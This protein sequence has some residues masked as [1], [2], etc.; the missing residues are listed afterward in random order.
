[1][2][3]FIYQ[4]LII[5]VLVIFNIYIEYTSGNNLSLPSYGSPVNS[6]F[7]VIFFLSFHFL[8][9]YLLILF[10]SKKEKNILLYS[11]WKYVPMVSFLIIVVSFFIM[12]L[13]FPSLFNFV[14]QYRVVL[15]ILIQYFLFLF[16]I[17]VFAII[18]KLLSTKEDFLKFSKRANTYSVWIVIGV[19]FLLFVV[20]G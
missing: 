9:Y 18:L 11:F 17:F 15:Y 6:V 19:F 4:L 16:Y 2:V 20:L 13:A 3:W 14:E 12:M 1:M 8:G 5:S 10:E 7:S